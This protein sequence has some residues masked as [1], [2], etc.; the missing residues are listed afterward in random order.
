[1]KKFQTTLKLG[2]A[3]ATAFALLIALS[4]WQST[5]KVSGAAL[6]GVAPKGSPFPAAI[7]VTVSFTI[8]TRKSGCKSGLGICNVESGGST[9]NKAADSKTPSRKVNGALV[10]QNDGSLE[11]EFSGK[12]PETGQELDIDQALALNADILKKLGVKSATIE[13]GKIPLSGS[14]AQLRAKILR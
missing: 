1:M 6:T 13:A 2:F 14:R 3:L 12:L 5:Q 9:V 10:L 11:L 8:A 4:T 7:R